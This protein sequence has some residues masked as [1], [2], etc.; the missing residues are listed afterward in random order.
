V[1]FLVKVKEGL[2]NPEQLSMELGEP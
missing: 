2:E 1:T